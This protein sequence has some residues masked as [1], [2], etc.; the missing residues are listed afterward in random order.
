MKIHERIDE[1]IEDVLLAHCFGC[2]SMK[3]YDE[4]KEEY[5]CPK[6]LI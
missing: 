1:A 3:M 2:E 5:Y 6:C 4:D